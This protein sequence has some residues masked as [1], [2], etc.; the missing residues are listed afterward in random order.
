MAIL[1]INELTGMRNVMER[2]VVAQGYTKVQVNAALQAIEN[3]MTGTTNV[4]PR[5][6]KAQLVLDI[7][8]A[9]AGFTAA[10]KDD[11]FVVWCL[12]NVRRGGLI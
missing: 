7:D 2:R 1:T 5:S 9:A 12:F 8:A 4:G 6:V 3:R 10:Q 11:L